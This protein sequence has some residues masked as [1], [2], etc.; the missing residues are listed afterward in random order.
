MGAPSADHMAIAEWAQEEIKQLGLRG[1]SAIAIDVTSGVIT[2]YS[3]WNMHRKA[4]SVEC[5][6]AILSMYFL[7]SFTYEGLIVNY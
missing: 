2:E 1:H 6:T 3:C 5:E 4:N 7:N